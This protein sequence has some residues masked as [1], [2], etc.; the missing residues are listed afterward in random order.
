MFQN[1]VIDIQFIKHQLWSV[2][3]KPP[4]TEVTNAKTT[5]ATHHV[6]AVSSYP[7]YMSSDLDVRFDTQAQ[8]LT[9]NL[10]PKPSYTSVFSPEP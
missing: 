7:W 2:Q 6:V 3:Q 9:V 8:A 5:L 4:P 10:K 1:L